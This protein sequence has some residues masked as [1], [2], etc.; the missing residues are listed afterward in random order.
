VPRL[1]VYGARA[2]SSDWFAAVLCEAPAHIV[3]VD[4]AAPSSAAN[5]TPLEAG[6]GDDATAVLRVAAKAFP[7]DDLILLRAGTALPLHWY[8]RLIAALALDDVLVASPLDNLDPARAPLPAG[9]SSDSAAAEVDVACW[10]CGR[11]EAIDWPT[12]SPLLSIWSGARLRGAPLEQF[13]KYTLPQTLAPARSVLLDHLFVADPAEKLHGPAIAPPGADPLPP[14]PLGELRELVAAVLAAPARKAD[15]Y[16]GLDAKP[17]VLHVLHGWGGGAERFVRDLAGND[18]ERHHLV[19]L[20]YGNFERRHFGETLELREA[21]LTLPALRRCELPNPIASTSFGDTVYKTCLDAVVRDF[22]VDA[23]MVSSLIG[24]SLD[25]LRTELPITFFVHDF[26]PLWPLLHRN[27]DDASLTFDAAQ[28]RADLAGIDAGFEFFEREA[29]YWLALRE[30]FADALLA[31]HAQLIAPTRAALDI[32]IRLQPRLAPLAQ[33]V[34]AHGIEP[35]PT[36]PALPLPRPPTRERLRLIVLGRVRRGKAA[37]M[38]R[39]LLPQLSE[40]AELFLI[41]A[42][43][44]VSEFFGQRDVHILLNYRGAE[45]P[46]LLERV[47]PDAALILPNFAETFSYTLSELTLLGIPV[48]ATRLGALGERVQ[49]E[50]DGFL[51]AP[52]PDDVLATIA[53]LQRDRSALSRVRDAVAA[54]P[55]RTPAAMTADYR[56]LLTLTHSAPSPTTRVADSDRIDASMLAGRLGEAK[57][58]T[59]KLRGDLAVLNH[60]LIRRGEWGIELERENRRIPELTERAATHLRWAH[61]AVGRERDARQNYDDLR[62]VHTHLEGEFEERTRWALSL[63]AEIAAQREQFESELRRMHESLSWR[64]TRPVRYAARQ[65]RALRASLAFQRARVRSAIGRTRGSF[66]RRG[67]IGTIKRIGDEFARRRGVIPTPVVVAPP[68]NDFMPFAVPGSDTPQVSI[69]IPVYNKI[70]YTA[71]CLRSLAER[72][73]TIAFEVI[74]VD[75]CSSDMTQSHLAQIPGIRVLRNEHNLG[76]VGSCNAGAALARGE[77]VLFLNNDTVVTAGW[78]AALVRCFEEEPD[79]GLVGAKLVY[80]DGRLQEAGGIVFSDGSGWNYGRF[81]DPADPRYDYR[82]EADYCSGA[83]IMLRTE[84]FRALGGFDTRYAPAYYEDTDLAFAT[85]AAGKKVYFEP[86]A[87]VVHFEGITSGTDLGS[88]I[89]Q[90]QVVN[91]EKFLDKWRDAL[92][93]QPAPIDSARLAPAAANFRTPKRVLIVDAYTPTPDQDSGSLRMVN[94]MRLL[95]TLGYH[96]SF[97]P[98]N[99]AHF[100]KYTEALQALGVEA[101]YHPYVADPGAWL[102]ENGPALDAIVLSRHYVA[103][104][105]LGLAR[106]YAPQARLIFDTVDLHYLREQRLATLE[107]SAE[108]ARQAAQTRRNELQL[109]RQSDVTLV[110]SPVE[111]ELLSR[112]V[113]GARIAVLSNVHEI[114]GC[115]R[116]Y[117][118]R[119]DLVF[120]GGFQHPP[121]IDAVQWFVRE[122][123]PLVRSRNADIAFHIVGSKLTDEVAAL[124]GDGVIVHG[125]VEDIAPFMDGCRLS[126]APLRY[127]AGVKGKV[128]MAMSYGLP[129]VATSTAVEG[130]HVRA[131]TAIADPDVLVADTPPDYASAILHAYGDEQ[132]WNTL[133]KN[134]LANV[135]RHFSFEAARAALRGILP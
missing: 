12:F 76:F 118:E 67:L 45:L 80:P 13:H 48:I 130:M 71:A 53:R 50:V 131:G 44:E 15:F 125:Y 46:A 73:D 85:R 6:A 98:D 51:V 57:R 17:V 4:G 29:S 89:K 35:W 81:G 133:S 77:F 100:E 14:S 102:R 32:F 92:A 120:V 31:A 41:G 30:A 127:G 33:H 117:A 2:A 128:N 56:E 97:L 52:N 119:K 54:K 72:A 43:P 116:A 101:L 96:V 114:Y 63:D 3:V 86:R 62:A 18:R 111:Q 87:R 84:F 26:Y 64:V 66:A 110:V 19:L 99:Y 38:L 5:A 21:A 11:R 105:Y 39:E 93:A 132:L 129:V 10:L 109:M 108:L 75:D 49:D 36:P 126:V 83:A 37:A 42:G 79:A 103:S 59:I 88:G 134:G 106:L 47:A 61:D 7:G 25:V 113:P 95:R 65:W 123:F 9:I 16:P 55:P 28:M 24:H 122:V 34:I 8:A 94:L 107:G 68:A 23:L 82:R 115:R 78:L 121:N 135:T 112:E 91:R 104:N 27:L 60:D 22:S 69:V 1:C 90:Y 70:E 58:E 74:V 20:A 124:A 40:Y